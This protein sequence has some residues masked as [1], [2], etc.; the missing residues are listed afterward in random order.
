M[1]AG[2]M[3]RRRRAGGKETIAGVLAGAL[4]AGC[5]LAWQRRRAKAAAFA[6]EKGERAESGDSGSTVMDIVEEAS[7]ESFPASDPPAW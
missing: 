7:E 3:R 5:V 1:V 6:A 4:L 2:E